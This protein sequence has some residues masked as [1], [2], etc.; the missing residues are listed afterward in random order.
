MTCAAAISAAVNIATER[1]TTRLD[2]PHLA[3]SEGLCT[4]DTSRTERR[5]TGRRARRCGARATGVSAGCRIHFQQRIDGAHPRPGRLEGAERQ[6]E[7]S[8]LRSMGFLLYRGRA[9][10]PGPGAAVDDRLHAPFHV[11][12]SVAPSAGNA[13]SGNALLAT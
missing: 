9:R 7:E 8:H 5:V 6:E 12:S 2:M 3:R 10:L 4:P 1:E 13:L 11:R